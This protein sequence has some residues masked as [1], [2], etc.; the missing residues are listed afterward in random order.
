MRM[1]DTA[2]VV[3]RWDALAALVREVHGAEALPGIDA[4]LATM[5]AFALGRYLRDVAA[6]GLARLRL[7][8]RFRRCT[9]AGVAGVGRGRRSAKAIAAGTRSTPNASISA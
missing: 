9:P 6:S 1:T 2:A 4:A 5:S 3:E 8:P 7:T